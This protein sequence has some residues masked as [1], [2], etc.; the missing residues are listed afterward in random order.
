MVR[1]PVKDRDRLGLF[2]CEPI[3]VAWT[4]AESARGCYRRGK[5]S[6][7]LQ[8]RSMRFDPLSDSVSM[9]VFEHL[10]EIEIGVNDQ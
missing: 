6:V 4:T 2:E 10:R 9:F 1:D 3:L 8:F 5:N 7:T